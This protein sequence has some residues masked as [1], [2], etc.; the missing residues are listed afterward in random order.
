AMR[1]SIG[2]AGPMEPPPIPIPGFNMRVV[3]TDGGP[4]PPA[5]Q[6][7]ETSVLVPV[8]SGRVVE[9]IA[10]QNGD[11]PLHCHMTHHVMNQMGHDTANTLGVDVRKADAKLARAVSGAMTM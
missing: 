11:W 4:I 3:A 7:P 1:L 2:N 5:G 9:M 6:W 10:E 8:G